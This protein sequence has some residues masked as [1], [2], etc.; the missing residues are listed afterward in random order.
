MVARGTLHARCLQILRRWPEEA[1]VRAG[2][3]V[4]DEE[5]QHAVLRKLRVRDEQVPN[6]LIMF[7]RARLQAFKLGANIEDLFQAYRGALRRR[8]LLDFDDLITHTHALFESHPDI[9]AEVAGEF[10]AV[11]VDEFQDLTPMQYGIVRALAEPHRN[12]FAVGDDEQSI[13]GF[14]GADPGVLQRFASDYAVEPVV[15]VVNHRNSRAIF[16]AARR[17]LSTLR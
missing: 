11:L 6:L 5:Y 3:G 16:D 12:L 15:L 10:D 2:F 9:R 13:Y 17:V 7:G 1:G 8:N 4:A 14:A